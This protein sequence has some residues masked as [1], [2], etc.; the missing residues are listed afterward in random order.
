MRAGLL[1][2]LESTN[3]RMDALGANLLIFGRDITPEEV[4]A[5]VEAVSHDDLMRVAA[6]IFAGRPTLAALGPLARLES[7]EKI[8]ARIAA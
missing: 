4:T 6:R 1:M 7:L 8:A 3:A 2:S 5:K